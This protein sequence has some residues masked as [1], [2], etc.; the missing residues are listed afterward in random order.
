[1]EWAV[2]SVRGFAAEFHDRD[3][4]SPAV[5]SLWWFELVRPALILGS[6]QSDSIVDYE[7][8]RRAGVDVV[9]RHSGGGAVL[10]VPGEVTWFDV[11]IPRSHPQW[12]DDVSRAAWWVGEVVARALGEETLT[13]HRGPLVP[14]AW[15]ATVCFA[16]LG[17][18][19]VT[20]SGAKVLGLSQRRTRELIR[21]QCALYR[22]WDPVLLAGLLAPGGPS[23]ADLENLVGVAELDL[24]ALVQS[25]GKQ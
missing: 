10:L 19:E 16:G 11:I 22:R 1:M 12:D 17:P 13:V 23:A 20:R 7:S 14:S 21:Y 8:C 2:E 25:L 3:L 4:P 5:P 6:T 24:D 18:G 15:S 9:R